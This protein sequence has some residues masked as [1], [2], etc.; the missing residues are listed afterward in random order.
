[1]AG[2]VGN[3]GVDADADGDGD[4]LEVGVTVPE[5]WTVADAAGFLVRLAAVP[6]TVSLTDF[7]DDAVVGDG[8]FGL[9]L[10]LRRRRVH[11]AKVA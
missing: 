11:R 6:V 7:T 8:R 9:E 5:I 1:M 10:P 4:A 2:R 3:S